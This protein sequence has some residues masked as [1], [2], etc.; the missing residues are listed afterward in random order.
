MTNEQ[1]IRRVITAGLL[2]AIT[3]L[4]V[5]ARVGMI[6]MPTPAGNATISHI[7]A[8]IGGILEGSV[9]GL[10][11]GLGFGF[12]SFMT[13]TIPM[14][15]DPLVA[16]VPR[17]FIGVTAGW[18]FLL[19]RRAD[20]TVLRGMIGVLWLLLAVFSYQMAQMILWLGIVAAVV[21]TALAVVL[22]LW[23][24]RE[25]AQIVALAIA[26][27]VGSMTNTV[28]VLTMAVVQGYIPGEAAIG[29]GITHGIPEVV[30]S[31]MIAVPVVVA[32]RQVGSRRAGGGFGARG[33][34]L[35]AEGRNKPSH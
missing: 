13:A 10:L 4:L 15:R 8:I 19:L 18:S 32:L 12:A 14:F 16:I 29:I 17:L 26:A 23:L 24:R 5:F 27:G 21:S 28:L 2:L 11:V 30:A 31:A 25:D 34:R 1:R 6:P 35:Q 3:L 22:F 20:K 9:V 7:P 33:S